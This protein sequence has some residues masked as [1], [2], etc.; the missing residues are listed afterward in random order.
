MN[1]QEIEI[2]VTEILMNKLGISET[3]L[4]LESTMKDLGAD[5]LDA[6]EIIF[7]L[8]KNFGVTFHD[9][10]ILEDQSIK[11]LCNYIENET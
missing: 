10:I 8:E 5:T 6:F 7:E 4:S 9:D 11:S 3:G 1:Q 2:K